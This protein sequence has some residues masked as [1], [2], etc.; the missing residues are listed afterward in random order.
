MEDV[1]CWNESACGVCSNWIAINYG[2]GV[3]LSKLIK[4]EY[5]LSV[6]M[7]LGRKPFLSSKRNE[8]SRNGC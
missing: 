1:F 7:Y 4:T 3:R 8:N 6:G 5:I 2:L